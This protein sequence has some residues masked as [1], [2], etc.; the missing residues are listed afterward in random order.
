MVKSQLNEILNLTDQEIKERWIHHNTNL[1]IPEEYKTKEQ[2]IKFLDEINQKRQDYLDQGYEKIEEV[3]QEVQK[4]L[5]LRLRREA[6]ELITSN[7]KKRAKIYTTRDDNNSEMYVYNKGIYIPEGKTYIREYNRH[8]L[9]EL[10]TTTIV[11]EVIAKIEADTYIEQNKFFENKHIELVPVQNGLLNIFTRELQ[12]FNSDIIFFNKLPM[13]YNPEAECPNV[14]RHFEEVLKE[15][16]DIKVM[17]ELFGYLLLRDY[18][19][20]KAVMLHGNGRNGKGKTVELMKRFIGA[21]N[22]TNITLEQLEKDNFCLGELFNKMANISAD[23][24]ST[25]LKNTGTFKSLTGHD[26][27]SAPRKFKT[28]IQFVNYAKMIYCSNDLPRTYDKSTAFFQRWVLFDFPFTFLSQKEIDNIGEKDA[29]NVKLADPE[30]INKLCDPLELSGLLN[31]AL[32]G[33]KRL[34]EQKD[35][36]DSPGTKDIKNRWIGKSDSFSAFLMEYVEE[37]W[38]SQITKQDL[39]KEYSNYCKKN[40][41]LRKGERHIKNVLSI[42]YGVETVRKSVHYHGED[43]PTQIRVWEGI[44][45]NEKYYFEKKKTG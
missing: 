13:E 6:T 19:I 45:W 26:L 2:I 14:I 44:K 22:C 17:Q 3:K 24:S 28:N 10:Y 27:I 42:D 36:S 40:K 16:E 43:Y 41:L 1:I 15:K 5:A 35:F 31:W 32:V 29:K 34:L 21:E 18:K 33:L 39:Q 25:S 30:L 20:E 11:N 8:V 7:I 12:P 4:A 37:D 9:D 38:D 23:I